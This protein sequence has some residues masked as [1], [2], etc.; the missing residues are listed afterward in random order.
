MPEAPLLLRAIRA[1]GAPR[2][3]VWLMRQAGRY[4]PEYRDLRR[5][6]SF[7]D[8]S[9]D[10]ELAARVTLLPMERF[11]LDAAI[12][13]ADIMSPL[14]GLGVEFGFDPG[15]VIGSP[16]R[17]PEGVDALLDPDPERL[18]PEV[19]AAITEVRAALSPEVAVIGFC[20]APW[21]LAA[22]LVQGHGARDFPRLRA[23]AAAR[24]DVLDRLLGKLSD[25]MAVYLIRQAAA[26]A[27][28]PYRCS[29]PG[30]AALAR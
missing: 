4:L 5:I 11:P 16:I 3:P 25:A 22:Y 29:I 26:G 6:H 27:P 2:R 28:T 9:R 15:P 14:A 21:T 8:L 10:P 18:A 12:V 19:M 24:P 7:R 17:G 13:F 1:E 23:F 20:G 30:G